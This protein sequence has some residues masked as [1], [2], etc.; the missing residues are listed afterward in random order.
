MSAAGSPLHSER[1]EVQSGTL[2]Q[3]KLAQP[4]QLKREADARLRTAYRAVCDELRMLFG[5]SRSLLDTMD[6]GMC[7]ILSEKGQPNKSISVRIPGV[8][9]GVRG[10]A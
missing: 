5:P 7:A 6:M 4:T 9:E 1:C 3:D 2:L 10:R 8:W